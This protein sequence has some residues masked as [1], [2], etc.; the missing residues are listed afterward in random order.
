MQ[1][2]LSQF[3]RLF[4]LL[5]KPLRAKIYRRVIS[6]SEEIPENIHFKLASSKDELAQAFCILH[7]AYVGCKLMKPHPSGMRVTPYHA[8]PTTYTLIAINTETGNVIGTLS[9]VCDSDFGLPSAELI[10]YEQLIRDRYS[11][12]E[13][14]ALA[15]KKEFKGQMLFPL[16]KFMY[17]TCVDLLNVDKVIAVLDAHSRAPELYESLLFFQRIN[18][19]IHTDYAFSNYK[20]VVAEILDLNWAREKY[21]SQYRK[22]PVHRNLF[23]FFTELSLDNFKLPSHKSVI[24]KLDEELFHYFFCEATSCLQEMTPKQAIVLKNLYK[25]LPQENIINTHPL[26]ANQNQYNHFGRAL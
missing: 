17:E 15:I 5:P 22:A 26:F 19:I 12:A 11:Y 4:N 8:L 18:Q 2:S 13:I 7:D 3:Q 14:S 16:M 9:I 20:P 24:P 10:G 6:V 23:S 1:K 25:G 21:R